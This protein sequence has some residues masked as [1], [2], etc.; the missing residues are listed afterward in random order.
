MALMLTLVLALMLTLMP[1]LRYVY[2]NPSFDG[3]EQAKPS[4]QTADL[5]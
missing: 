3:A 1:T 5:V 4:Y 2:M